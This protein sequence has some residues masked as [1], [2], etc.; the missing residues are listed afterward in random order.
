MSSE[1]NKYL[2]YLFIT[3]LGFYT[4]FFFYSPSL[5]LIDD[6]TMLETIQKGKWSDLPVWG[7]R[8]FPLNGQEYNL[9]AK[10]F[11]PQPWAYYLYNAI[12]VLLLAFCFYSLCTKR[13]G[14]KHTTTLIAL[15]ALMLTPGF[16]VAFHRLYVP[17]RN[18]LLLLSLFLYFFVRFEKEK[19]P[20]FFFVAFLFCNIAFY[21]K[22]PT[23]VLPCGFA[24]FHMI[25]TKKKNMN[26]H[27]PNFILM[28]SG[29]V[30]LTLYF[31][32][33]YKVNAYVGE[34]YGAI[35]YSKLLLS[36][37]AAVKYFF[38]D[39][40]IVIG[41][42]PLGIVRAYRFLIKRK[43]MNPL[44]DSL[45]FAGLAY[46]FL[47]IA[48]KLY[49]EYYLLPCYAFL[50]PVFIHY[51]S[52]QRVLI[53][54]PRW[55][56]ITGGICLLSS[57]SMGVHFLSF[58]R[59]MPGNL[60]QT[61]SFLEEQ[62]FEKH[63]LC[64][65][66]IITSLNDEIMDSM[67]AFLKYKNLDKKFDLMTCHKVDVSET[68]WRLTTPYSL[69]NEGR[70]PGKKIS[71]FTSNVGSVYPE[72]GIK[73]FVKAILQTPFIAKLLPHGAIINKTMWREPY[74]AIHQV[75]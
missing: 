60:Q 40:L 6:W 29:I 53:K 67:K 43:E 31:Y 11:G 7:D 70:Y 17:E 19:R 33:V 14:F 49:Q 35:P 75:K 25:F 71:V 39:P 48:L 22:E 73:T 57:L 58:Y 61:L 38:S 20:L 16:S 62:N 50:M 5:G 3:F 55:A 36:V 44:Y 37:K 32:V 63:P 30:F 28:A 72:Y 8:F 21:Y 15:T 45:L 12:E 9:I 13:L 52:E 64:I 1:T 24:F 4:L 34:G 41:A 74:F 51:I 47:F 23:F 59:T 2:D 42:V 66:G 26:E 56:Q 18:T 10:V 65:E 46:F 27:W 54:L 68:H 69:V